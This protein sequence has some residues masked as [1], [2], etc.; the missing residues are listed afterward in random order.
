VGL[1]KVC[2]VGGHFFNLGVVEAFDFLEDVEIFVGNEVDGNSL[3]TK[4]KGHED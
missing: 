1:K 2:D 3:T 4:S